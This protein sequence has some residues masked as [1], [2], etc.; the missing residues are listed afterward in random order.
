VVDPAD[1][2][3]DHDDAGRSCFGPRRELLWWSLLV[4][5]ANMAMV[6]Q[7]GVTEWLAE[8][9]ADPS[10]TVAVSPWGI[11]GPNYAMGEAKVIAQSRRG[12]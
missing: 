5:G 10:E 6:G 9:I 4:Q 3:S 8:L 12:G 11:C 2:E 7:R 1:I